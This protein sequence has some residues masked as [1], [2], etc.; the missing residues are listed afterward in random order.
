M[1][2]LG[3]MENIADALAKA[4]NANTLKYVALNA[5]GTDIPSRRRLQRLVHKS[6]ALSQI[7]R[8]KEQFNMNN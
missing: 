6:D 8:R 1:N 7:L 3:T 4:V 2:K 5:D